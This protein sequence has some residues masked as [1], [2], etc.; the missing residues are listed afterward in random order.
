M[1]WC[2]RT[3]V[4]WD[5]ARSSVLR[6]LCDRPANDPSRHCRAKVLISK[7]HEELAEGMSHERTGGYREST[8]NR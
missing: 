2:C 7:I 1:R 6:A 4:L 3:D 5:L 8:R